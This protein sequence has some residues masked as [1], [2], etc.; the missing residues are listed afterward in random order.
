MTVSVR[1]LGEF[2]VVGSCGTARS[3]SARK[4]RALLAYLCLRAGRPQQREHV[5]LLLWGD[6]SSDEYARKSLRQALTVLRRDLPPALLEATR[7]EL[8]IQPD[9]ARIDVVEFEALARLSDK[10]SLQQAIALYRG[11]LL[12][13]FRSRSDAFD[14]WLASE[15]LRLRERVVEALGRLLSIQ[16]GEADIV[17]ATETAIR[18][19]SLDPLRE[20]AHRALMQA[21]ADQGR[22]GDALDQYE[23]CRVV[24]ERELGHGPAAETTELMARLRQGQSHKA[25]PVSGASTWEAISQLRVVAVLAISTVES[26]DAADEAHGELLDAVAEQ[27]GLVLRNTNTAMVVTFG[28]RRSQGSEVVR[29]VCAALRIVRTRAGRH[30]CGIAYAQAM[31]TRTDAAVSVVGDAVSQA[32]HLAASAD[33]GAIVVSES[34]RQ[35]LQDSA[36]SRSVTLVPVLE[37]AGRAR[38][39]QV[40]DRPCE[41]SDE[42]RVRFVGRSRETAILEA[43]LSACQASSL[44][45][46]IV[47]RG[48][49]GIGKTRLMEHCAWLA[50]RQGYRTYRAAALDFGPQSER[51]VVAQLTRAV[52][53]RR[54]EPD[55]G[56]VGRSADFEPKSTRD[57]NLLLQ[58]AGLDRPV[59][60]EAAGRDMREARAARQRE[61]WHELWQRE[62]VLHATLLLIED[63]HWADESA[64]DPITNLLDLMQHSPLIVLVST[65]PDGSAESPRWLGALRGHAVTSLDLGPFSP[66]EGRELA[67]ELSVTDPDLIATA[68]GR[69]GGHP[70]F[71]EQLL[72][73]NRPAELT[74]S[75]H[76]ALQT[77]VD[78]LAPAEAAALG[79]ASVLGLQFDLST[80]SELLERDVPVDGL[81]RSGLIR[82]PGGRFMFAHALI[83]D[84]VYETLPPAR[85]RQLHSRAA[86][87]VRHVD[88]GL[89]AEHLDRAEDVRAA[90]VYLEAA[91][92]AD[93][94][95]RVSAA[96]ELADRGLA[97]A[98]DPGLGFTLTRVRARLLRRLGQR[99]AAEQAARDALAIATTNA[100]R[101]R[102]YVSLAE[103]LRGTPRDGEALSALESAQQTSAADDHATRSHIH[104]L[105]GSVLF[106]SGQS[107]A[108]LEAHEQALS[109]AKLAGS[110]NAEARALSGL[111]DA[112]YIQGDL[113][114]AT[115]HFE[116]CVTV[117]DQLG[118]ARLARVN[119][120][121]L[122]LI[123]VFMLDRPAAAMNEM[124]NHAQLAHE[125]L[126]LS[127]E[128]VA[129]SSAM[130]GAILCSDAR[131]REAIARQVVDIARRSGRHRL[132]V[133]AAAYVVEAQVA[134]G[135]AVDA[136]R[137]LDAIY[138]RC[139][140]MDVPFAALNLLGPMLA[141][142]SDDERR[143]RLFD[144]ADQVLDGGRYVSHCLYS[145]CRFALDV[146]LQTRRFDRVERYASI[147]ERYSQPHEVCWGGYFAEW[148][149]TLSQWQ[150]GH[151]DA[152]IQRAL[153]ALGE[154]ARANG[155]R[156]ESRRV[157][158]A[159]QA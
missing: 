23:N 142:A 41:P 80:L 104:Y 73:T 88:L 2:E 20:E 141:S 47:V 102:A 44:G 7:D 29:A 153:L 85:K 136:D 132:G 121:M 1:L 17:G 63:L 81:L 62:T 89:V 57:R 124:M 105:I 92:E 148:A 58:L 75:I 59:S 93:S 144:E 78:Q 119:R 51:D 30:A 131:E 36:V 40:S 108:S 146:C 109:H 10:V 155:M 143:T 76:A 25:A 74:E 43:M 48:E 28:A 91:Q 15:R 129:R 134:Q 87:A 120:V 37:V 5:A 84:A 106:P 33:P 118:L 154:T 4:A 107:Q 110:A 39:W 69:S 95:E 126:D 125:E 22:L 96:L 127:G 116:R 32:G 70:L 16:R 21:Y 19:V 12:E 86:R 130:F 135:K 100:Q 45:Q 55:S 77:R 149:R 156:L 90:E 133:A 18:M 150:R 35:G 49:A 52:L 99:D 26:P 112:Y 94:Q 64:L 145:F 98:A 66:S 157:D 13:G 53:R 123:R 42:L 97:L 65:R 68:I 113:R 46:L 27:G 138:E 11:E 140:E 54:A 3:V 38:V 114:R 60:T 122:S 111:G 115:Q 71:L 159:L 61:L 147:L 139:A 79:A 9:Q 152:T 101:A 56:P 6:V 72:R 128:A 31:V 24:L 151:R 137:Q 117:A 14:D 50:E 83:R 158:E 82:N 103:T 34:V 8:W 67:R